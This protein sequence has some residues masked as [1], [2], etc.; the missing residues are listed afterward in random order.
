MAHELSEEKKLNLGS[1][2][3]LVHSILSSF[4][5]NG[6]DFGFNLMLLIMFWATKR[7]RQSAVVP[8]TLKAVCKSRMW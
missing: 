8:F 5:M 1:D 7:T 3:S 6:W 2:H 4:F